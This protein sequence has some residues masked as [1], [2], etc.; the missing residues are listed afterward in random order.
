[1]AQLQSTS[2][3]GSLIVTGGITGSFSGSIVAPGSTT[4]VLFNNSGVISADSGFVYSGGNVGIGTTSPQSKLQISSGDNSETQLLIGQGSLYG[5]PSIRFK[6]AATNYMG[7][8]FITGSVVGNEVIDALAIQRTGNV[9]IGTTNPG[10]KLEIQDTTTSPTLLITADGGNQQLTIKRYSTPNEQLIFGFHSSDYG[11]VQAVEQGVAYRAFALNPDGGNVGIGT[12]NPGY[13]LDVNGSGR[14]IFRNDSNE[15]MDL[16]L[17]TEGAASKSKLSL[18]WYGNE[19]AALKFVRGGNS[20]GGSMEFWTQQDGGSTTQK[21]TITG[22]GNVGIGTSSPSTKLDVDGTGKFGAY[23]LI[24]TNI[25]AGYYQ[26]NVNGA[27]RSL[28]GAGDKGYYFQGY[29]GSSTTMY[30]GL[31][32]SYAGRI[33]IGTTTPGYDIHIA[34]SSTES[35]ILTT[36][37]ASEVYLSHGGWSMGAG[38]FG[39][40]DAVAGPTLVIDVVNDRIGVGSGIT[41]PAYLIDAYSTNSSTNRISIGGTSNF[42]LFQAFNTSGVYYL[43]IDNSSGTGFSQGGYA[44]VLY[45]SGAYPLVI[46]TD[47][48][49]R[50]RITG[51]GNVGIGTNNPSAK[52][53]VDGN[54]LGNNNGSNVFSINSVGANYGF[55]LNNSANT[56]SL[57]YG[58]SLSTVGTSVLTWNSSGYVGIGTT[59]PSQPLEVN[60]R[61][62]VNQFQYTKAINYSGGDLNSLVTAGFYDGSSL[63]NAP[64]GNSGWFYITVETYS[65]DNNWIHQTATTFGSG[66]TAN[67]VYTRVRAS[68]TWGSWKKLSDSGDI[69]GTTNYIPKFTGTNSIGNSVIYDNS[70]NIGLSTTSPNAKLHIAANAL[71]TSAGDYVLN[72]IH[73]NS[74]GNSEELEIKS[75]RESAGNDWTYGGKRIQLRIDSTYMGYMQFNGYGN[76]AGISFGTGTTTSA[77]G[78]VAERMRITSGGAVGI[79]TSSPQK[80]LEA[81]SGVNNFVSVGVDQLSVGQWS[82]IHF[83]YREANTLYRKS[84]IVF[85]RTDLTEGNAQGKIHILNGPQSGN[86]SA[87]LSDARLTISENGNVGIGTTTPQGKLSIDGGNIYHN[88]GNAAANYYLYLNHNSSYDGGMLW[89]RDNSTFDWQVN[90]IGSNGNLWFY[91]Y[92]ISNIALT[93]VKSTGYVGIGTTTPS[94]KLTVDGPTLSIGTESSYALRILNGSSKSLTLGGDSSNAYIQS[95][96]SGPL[97]INNQGNNVVFNLNGGSVG[98]GTSPSFPLHVYTGLAS[99]NVIGVDN[100]TQTLTLGVNNSAGGSFLFENGNNAL[101]FGTNG[102]ERMRISSVGDVGVGTTSP[103]PLLSAT[104]RVIEISNSNLASLYL[105]STTGRRWSVSSIATGELTFWDIDAVAERMRIDTSGNVGIGTSSPGYKLDVNGNTNVNGTLTATTKS[106]IIDHPTKEG[107]KLQYGVLEGPEHSVYVRGKLMNTH[108][109]ELPDYWHAL[110]DEDSIT[111]NLTAIGR[112]QELWVEEITDKYITVGSETAIINCFYTVFAERKDVEKLVTEFDKE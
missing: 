87:T 77:P 26:D 22:D 100:G 8:G 92:G 75:V 23:A 5:A 78:N 20:T 13:K 107:K 3:T 68:G 63:S 89:T 21:M 40:G 55:I 44:R 112:K 49:E 25:A 93:M 1:M 70:G 67:E 17:S 48:T 33:G 12:T 15:I 101:R 102:N 6:Q 80:A 35:G 28:S 24:G 94:N 104:E 111:V 53:Q 76:N 86:S 99:A 66:N 39:I 60:G 73:Y 72:S 91:S 36:Y 62:L 97:H 85:E 59:T 103:S 83:G 4:Q 65:G 31:D 16:L 43:G 74:N 47:S 18:L 45:S 46:S 84:A 50:M 9:G 61:T 51:G 109:I 90:N 41:S 14:F 105:D 108:R 10:A 57:G 38:K 96:S 11:Y 106:F 37:G 82:G 64:L 71:G 56:F 29:N 7:L 30:V 95:W 32:G 69:S 19:T 79:N 98:I 58:P 52:L 2:I 34:K 88:Y 54:I 27:Y 110:V 42:S 81:I